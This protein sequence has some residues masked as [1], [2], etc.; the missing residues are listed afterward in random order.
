MQAY[1]VTEASNCS[2][3]MHFTGKDFPVP[4]GAALPNTTFQLLDKHQKAVKPGA[5]GEIVLGGI[6]IGNGYWDRP[7]LTAKYFIADPDCP[8]QKCYRTGDLAKQT[9]EGTYIFIGRA[10]RQIKYKDYRIE[11]DEIER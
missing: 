1:G 9:P 7:E 4:L 8:G 10:D 5:V 2:S 11:L 6:G 3:L